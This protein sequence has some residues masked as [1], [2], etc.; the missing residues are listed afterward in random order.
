MPSCPRL[1][2]KAVG[3]PH[4]RTCARPPSERAGRIRFFR[5]FRVGA[6]VC[7][8]SVLTEEESG[9]FLFIPC[10]LS[11]FICLLL[12]ALV[13]GSL[14]CA[15]LLH[16]NGRLEKLIERRLKQGFGRLEKLNE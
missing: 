7:D 3:K 13:A 12:S 16:G 2:P 8:L 4:Q 15:Y 14:L 1:L 9:A 10:Q 11:P 5:L 6:I